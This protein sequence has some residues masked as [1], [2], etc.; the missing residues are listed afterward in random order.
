MCVVCVC[1]TSMAMHRRRRE[2][3][4]AV[5]PPHQLLARMFYYYM[6]AF[7]NVFFLSLSL[8][9]YIWFCVHITIWV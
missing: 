2:I 5:R 4:N 8:S 3:E 9:F 1:E 7:Y 6:F